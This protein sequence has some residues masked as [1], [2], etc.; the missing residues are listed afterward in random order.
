MKM[1]STMMA[2][3]ALTA[4]AACGQE[5]AGAGEEA[6]RVFLVR[7]TKPTRQA[8]AETIVQTGSIESPAVVDLAPKVS[9]RLVATSL[10]DGTDVVEGT[11][12]KAGAAIARLDDRDYAAR[13]AVAEAG[14]AAAT[15]TLEDARKEFARTEAL[16]KANTATEQ[17]AD[18]AL[19]VLRRAEAG[20]GEAEA[21]LAL[22]RLNLEETVL[23]APMDA[24]VAKKHLHPGAMLSSASV[25]YRLVAMDELRI[26]FDVPTTR[27]AKLKPGETDVTVVVDAYPEEAL[28][29]PVF[30]VHPAADERTRTVR[31]ELRL[32][33]AEGKYLPGMYVRGELALDRR[34]NA[35]VVPHECLVPMLDRTIVYEV[36]DGRAVAREVTLGTRYDDV[37]EILAGLGEDAEIVS[38]GTHRLADGVAV[39]VE[40]GN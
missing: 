15:A 25:V 40:Q 6:A 10:E 12:V 1:K 18:R 22:A 2:L 14:L 16:L 32:P 9:G 36:V 8:I 19:T 21:A 11:A 24:R 28:H 30:S 5:P 17:E 13:V 29:L 4:V 38:M 33:N 7:T 26:F 39:K 31:V 20:V 23:K 3:A 35:L 37:Q 27:F 34:E